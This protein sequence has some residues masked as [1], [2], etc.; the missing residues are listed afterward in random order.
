M[1]LFSLWSYISSGE[2]PWQ[3][4]YLPSRVVLKCWT[5]CYW[6]SYPASARSAWKWGLISK[7]CEVFLVQ[8][9][10]PE[11]IF[12]KD[13]PWSQFVSEMLLILY[14]SS[15][16][17][18]LWLPLLF[19]GCFDLF[20]AVVLTSALEI[21]LF[22]PLWVVQGRCGSW[23]PNPALHLLGQGT[24]APPQLLWSC[25]HDCTEMMASALFKN[26]PLLLLGGKWIKEKDCK[27]VKLMSPLKEWTK[28]W[29]TTHEGI[30]FVP[31]P[32]RNA[33]LS[34][35]LWCST[36]IWRSWGKL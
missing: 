8:L 36:Y 19:H 1:A 27:K 11:V 24:W 16:N 13:V 4:P 15:L 34:P 35:K 33:N 32:Y 20:E 10:A 3:N 28:T 12:K 2:N 5:F 21:A 7:T 14:L 25:P 6:D 26:T 23:D 9:L 30:G 29:S 17:R 18:C 31:L 22:F